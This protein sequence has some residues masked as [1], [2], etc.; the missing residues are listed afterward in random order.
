M[1]DSF[2]VILSVMASLVRRVYFIPLFSTQIL[3]HK[4][5]GAMVVGRLN[6]RS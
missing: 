2:I 3:G 5:Y 4:L 1:I 6:F